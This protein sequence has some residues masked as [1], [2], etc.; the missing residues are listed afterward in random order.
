[1]LKFFVRH[2][3]TTVMFVLFW[4]LLGLVAYPK[5]NVERI[6]PMDLPLVSAV[7]VYPGASPQDI[8]EQVIKPIEDAVSEVSQIKR[9]TSRSMNNSGFVLVEF[10]LGADVNQKSLEVKDKVDVLANE[11]PT[12]LQKP[13]IQKINPL[14]ESVMDIAIS[15]KCSGECYNSSEFLRHAYKYATD[16]LSK[17]ITSISGVASVSVYGGLERAIRI[18]M[19]PEIMTQKGISV[20]D[21]T[22]A[23]AI[24][25][26]NFPG[27]K[28]EQ[29]DNSLQVRFIGEFQSVDDIANMPITTAEGEIFKLKDVATVMDAARKQESGARMNAEDVVIISIVKAQDG[30]AIKISEEF[31]KRFDG[32]KADV[33]TALGDAANLSVVSDSSLSILKETNGTFHGI[34]LGMFLT[35]IILLI[36]TKNWR[37]TIISCVVIPASLISGFFLMNASGFSIN[38]LT[39]LAMAT[40]LGTL[41]FNAII[42]IESAL[43]LL[44]QGAD[45]ETAAIDGTKRVAVSVIAGAGTNIAVFL[46]IAFMGGIAGLFM[47]QFGMSVVYFT[48]L[49]IMFSFSL[50]PMMV[51]AMLRPTKNDFVKV[52]TKNGRVKKVA[53]PAALSSSKAWFKKIFDYEMRHP[54]IMVIAAFTVLFGSMQLVRF[55]GNAFVPA[56]DVSEITIAAKA[57]KG[58]TYEK[59]VEIARSIEKVLSKFPEVNATSV[60]IGEN[61]VENVSVAALLV[62]IEKRAKSDKK[63]AQEFIPELAE[64]VDAE[65]NVK[66]GKSMAGQNADLTMNVIGEDDA[67]REAY[68]AQIVNIINSLPEIQSAQ[69]SASKPGF[70]Y[71]FIPNQDQMNLYGVSNQTAAMI[72]RSALYGNDDY[73]Y[74]EDGD[75]IPMVVDMAPEFSNPDVFNLI[76]VKAVK[77]LVPLSELGEIKRAP[78]TPDIY[79]RDKHRY[80]EIQIILGKSTIGP[81]QTEITKQIA[82]QIQFE[83]GYGYYFAGMGEMQAETA[84]EMGNAFLLAIILTYMLLAAILNSLLHP[85]TIATGILTSFA[86]VFVI[87][88]LVGADLNIAALLS[89]IMLV[90]LAVNNNIILLEPTINL[91]RSGKSIKDALWETL[92]DRSRMILMTTLAVMAGMIPQLWAADA[93][94]QSMGAVIVGGMLAALIFTYTFTPAL[95]LLFERLRQRMSYSKNK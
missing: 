66:A 57:P 42:I 72:L 8:E 67:V 49:S 35:V 80:T 13:Q 88:F 93:M 24:K 45:P 77:G 54:W 36:F 25:N 87:M 73:N 71:R 69:L 83:D 7:L 65:I 86:G 12:G 38:G 31:N 33:K 6:P 59:S 18:Q 10:V 30:N 90:G 75:E 5:M 21:I 34:I 53:E 52:Q 76:S 20:L 15:E 9:V 19:N 50:T 92:S 41:I 95:F 68:A 40:A 60:K 64:I 3:I 63:L 62:P 2:P 78:A 91:I 55:I 17:Q 43:G 14:Q 23:L 29:G 56:T 22:S 84:G 94:K 81:V 82:S 37:T 39:L 4:V 61:G 16:T 89:I 58:A 28:I 27:G 51:K 32:Y 48:L 46:P 11:L 1:M 70:E 47:K 74:R 26:L 44:H 79:R 85:F